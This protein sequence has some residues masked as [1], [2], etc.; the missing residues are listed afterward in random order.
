VG[1]PGSGRHRKGWRVSDCRV[2]S[3]SDLTGSGRRES[4][5]SGEIT[6]RRGAVVQARLTFS[7]SVARY[8]LDYDHWTMSLRYRKTMYA[9]ESC[10]QVTLAMLQPTMAH[11]PLCGGF[12]RKLYAPP[13]RE[14]FGCRRCQR[15]GYQRR[16]PAAPEPLVAPR[17]QAALGS[18]LEGLHDKPTRADRRVKAKRAL[19]ESLAADVADLRPQERRIYCLRLSKAGYSCRAIARLVGT[20]KSSVQRILA[21]GADAVDTTVLVPERLE[22]YRTTHPLS[23]GELRDG[24]RRDR[25]PEP[26]PEEM[27]L[28]FG[29]AQA[30]GGQ[31]L[32]D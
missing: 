30:E 12:A 15:L 20:S 6:W 22:R 13:Y 28:T 19:L 24:G 8:P 11:C 17:I 31:E 10:Q 26:E 3:V 16:R 18:V 25:T 21:A 27:V 1:G 23:L 5:P 9:A 4:Q 29:D 7:I 2:L 32:P 14:H